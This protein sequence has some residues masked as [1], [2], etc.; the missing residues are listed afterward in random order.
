M[1]DLSEKLAR[2]RRVPA[3]LSRDAWLIGNLENW[4]EALTA[5]L[6]HTPLSQVRL[7]SGVVL[8]CPHTIDLAFLFHETWVRR[9][10]SPPGYEIGPGETI[11]DIGANI[12]VFATFAATRAAGVRVFSY[13]PFPENV[14]WLR[15][16]INKSGLT[17][18]QV[19][20]Q[21]VSGNT[22]LRYLQVNS[23]NWIVHSLFGETTTTQPGLQIDSVSFDD[24][25]SKE[26]IDRCDLL[27]LDCEGSE[28]EILQRCAPETLKRVRRIVG[29]YHEGPH[30]GGTGEQLCRFLESRSFRIDN[31]KRDDGFGV[32]SAYNLAF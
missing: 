9:I 2:V 14:K 30:I 18:V 12:G 15:N 31:F 1:S 8:E 21:A 26:H 24:I 4:R 7:R 17:N 27:K 29:E 22:G 13:E 5:E 19:F 32:L 3:R 20:Q 10:Y 11:I 25:M 23:D 16:N 28:Y 6:R